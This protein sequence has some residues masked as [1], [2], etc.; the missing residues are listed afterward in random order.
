MRK[1][2]VLKSVKGQDYLMKSLYMLTE[3]NLYT[4]KTQWCLNTPEYDLNP[5]GKIIKTPIVY[6]LNRKIR[7]HAKYFHG[8]YIVLKCTE[9]F[10]QKYEKNIVSFIKP[11]YEDVQ[12]YLPAWT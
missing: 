6:G 5:V 10:Y 12:R 1:V 11:D 9:E 3:K 7:S 8:F 4:K 2:L